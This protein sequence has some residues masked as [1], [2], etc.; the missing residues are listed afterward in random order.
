[1]TER[2]AIK[3]A[4]IGKEYQGFQRQTESIKTVEGTILD[5]LIELEIINKV[6]ESRYSAAGRTDK[7]VNA[8]SQVI[9]FD[10][11]KNKI[12]LE[13]INDLLPR[14]IYAWAKAEVKENFHPRRDAL[15]RTYRL[16]HYYSNENLKLMTKAMK[17]LRGTHDFVKL[18]KKSDNLQD[19]SP[20]STIL[21][22]ETAKFNL[23]NDLLEFEF[24]SRSFLWN[25]VRKMVSV[26]LDIG[27]GKYP[28]EILDEILNPP[29]SKPKGGIKPV[30]PYGLV[31][32]DI[33]YKN[34]K[35]SPITKK[36]SC[37]T[38]LLEKL[39]FYSST[40]AVLKL[41]KDTITK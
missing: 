28:P 29:T 16:Y 22:L 34:I 37:E 30:P 5:T 23:Q 40:S 26:I 9:A 14:D 3:I 4:Y 11:L 13:E 15:L 35:F 12:Y 19:G 25:Q 32:Y 7:G 6:S 41:M 24:S 31:L 18:C 8:I 20:K 33:Y 39:N 10:S 1:M 2:F 36:I 21:T 27:S 38:R 17:K